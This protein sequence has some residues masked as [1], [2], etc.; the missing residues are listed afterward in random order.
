[1]KQKK[2]LPKEEK[3]EHFIAEQQRYFSK[4]RDGALKFFIIKVQPQKR[5]TFDPKESVDMQGQI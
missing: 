1:M 4:N 5:M 2:C 3:L